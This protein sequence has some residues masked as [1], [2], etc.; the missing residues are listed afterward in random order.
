VH[1]FVAVLDAREVMMVEV[2][3]LEFKLISL[4]GLAG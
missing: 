2:K 3:R 4:D 1:H